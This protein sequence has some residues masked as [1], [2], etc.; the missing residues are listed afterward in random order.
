MDE[1]IIKIIDNAIKNIW[2][3]EDEATSWE[4]KNAAWAKNRLVEL[5]ASYDEKKDMRF[6]ISEHQYSAT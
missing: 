4:R 1:N 2:E 6:Y 5:N 3:Y